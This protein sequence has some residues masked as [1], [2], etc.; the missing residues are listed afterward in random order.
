MAKR[1]ECPACGSA[2]V[3]PGKTGE[4]HCRKCSY[5]GPEDLFEHKVTL[6]EAAQLVGLGR[7]VIMSPEE[8]QKLEKGDLNETVSDVG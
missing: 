5:R 1:L 3:I 4:R 6:E 8:R 7:L 2:Y